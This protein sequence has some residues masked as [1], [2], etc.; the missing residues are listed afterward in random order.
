MTKLI[1]YNYSN[2]NS[3]LVIM[4]LLLFSNK[5]APYK[6]FITKSTLEFLDP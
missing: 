4:S 5:K 2:W 1:C 3:N 6:L